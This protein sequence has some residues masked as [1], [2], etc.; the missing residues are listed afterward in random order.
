MI[1]G[2]MKKLTRFEKFLINRNLSKKFEKNL[3]NNPIR[4][5]N[6]SDLMYYENVV[7]YVQNSFS[8]CYSPEGTA[9]WVNVNVEWFDCLK[10]NTL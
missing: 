7:D 4:F 9:F 8:W 5:N 10:N 3:K 1:D 2:N 6:I